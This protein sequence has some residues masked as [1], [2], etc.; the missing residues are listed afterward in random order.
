MFSVIIPLYNKKNFIESS[1]ASALTQDFYDYEIIVV[2]DGSTD[3]SADVVASIS[4]PRIRLLHQSNQGVGRARNTGIGASAKPWIAFLDADDIWA[5]NHLSTLSAIITAKPEA[6]FVSTRYTRDTASNHFDWGGA[7][8]TPEIKICEIDYFAWVIDNPSYFSTISIAVRRD[9]L[10]A[11]GGF[12]DFQ[13]GQDVELWVRLA[14]VT[15]S[16]VG[17]TTTARVRKDDLGISARAMPQVATEE[18]SSNNLPTPVLRLLAKHLHSG[19]VIANRH[20]V[21]RFFDHRLLIGMRA[22]LLAGD[23]LR[24]WKLWRLMCSPFSISPLVNLA[25]VTMPRALIQSLAMRRNR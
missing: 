23:R 22:A 11:V 4:D 1:I 9:L 18:L 7:L 2:D 24:A 19:D 14:F 20:S 5:P 15:R 13:P 25:G 6:G 17:K 16:A 12:G 8:N 3:G 21:E 10:H